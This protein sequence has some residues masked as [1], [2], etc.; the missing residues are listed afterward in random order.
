[1]ANVPTI[2]SI[3]STLPSVKFPIMIAIVHRIADGMAPHQACKDE[4]TTLAA[5]KHA[6]SIEPDLKTL[7][8]EALETGSEVLA[9]ML[10]HIDQ[11]H[12]DPRFARIISDNIKWLLER[13]KPDKYGQ[14]VQV[15]MENN[16][17]KTMM[18]ILDKAIDRIPVAR[19]PVGSRFVD[20]TFED[21]ID[22][23]TPSAV[24]P[25]ALSPPNETDLLKEMGLL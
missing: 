2:G 3:G 22:K 1:M 21:V 15:S 23:K 14:R 13:R 6:M 17:T 12:S 8:D 20:V 18:E 25:T 4:G 24:A 19:A 5:F 11:E 9:D 10:L 7:F 16:A